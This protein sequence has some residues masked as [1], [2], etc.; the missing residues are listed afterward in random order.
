[1]YLAAVDLTMSD[2][3]LN[4]DNNLAIIISIITTALNPNFNAVATCN[5]TLVS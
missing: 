2:T 4:P 1:M 3:N 5:S